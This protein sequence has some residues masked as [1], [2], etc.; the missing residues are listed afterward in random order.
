MKYRLKIKIFGVQTNNIVLYIIHSNLNELLLVIMLLLKVWLSRT[1]NQY[2]KNRINNIP[3]TLYMPTCRSLWELNFPQLIGVE[4]FYILSQPWVRKWLYLNSAMSK[5]VTLGGQKWNFFKIGPFSAIFMQNDLY[6][7]SSIGLRRFNASKMA[8]SQPKG[9]NL[10]ILWYFE[11]IWA[12]LGHIWPIWPQN[13]TKWP[14]LTFLVDFS[15]FL[16][17]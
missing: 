3:G 6:W 5:N 7:G 4:I 1:W 15:A 11:V 16:M 12:I 17:R 13:I 9:S 14:I 8:K 10:T 2:L